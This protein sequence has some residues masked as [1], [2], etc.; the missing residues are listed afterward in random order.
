[1]QSF[2]LER[3]REIYEVE[4]NQEAQV[5]SIHAGLECAIIGDKFE[6]MDMISFGPDLRDPHSPNERLYIPSLDRTWRFMVAL[7]VSYGS[8]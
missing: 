1:M 5:K 6:G 3:C 7:L 4:F 8:P 2:L